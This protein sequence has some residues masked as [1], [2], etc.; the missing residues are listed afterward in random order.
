MLGEKVGKTFSIHKRLGQNTNVGNTNTD[1]KVGKSFTHTILWQNTM[2]STSCLFPGN[3]VNVEIE[4]ELQ[5]HKCTIE[6]FL[7][8]LTYISKETFQRKMFNAKYYLCEHVIFL[9]KQVK[10]YS[11]AWI[12]MWKCFQK[13]V[14]LFVQTHQTFS[15][16]LRSDFSCLEVK[17]SFHR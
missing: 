7:H 14:L 2:Q 12:S 3:E 6:H 4:R 1:T 9:F 8:L 13:N 5:L 17:I 11:K 15:T 16:Q 10:Q